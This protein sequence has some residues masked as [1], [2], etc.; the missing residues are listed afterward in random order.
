MNSTNWL[1]SYPTWI[2]SY[3]M[4][5]L[6]WQ[7]AVFGNWFDLWTKTTPT[8]MNGMGQTLTMQEKFV[9][10]LLEIEENSVRQSLDMQKM[11]W[12]NYFQMAGLQ[13]DQ[14]KKQPEEMKQNLEPFPTSAKVST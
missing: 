8:A 5:W 12:E 10:N 7:R 13:K 2:Y 14:M 1:T 4:L 9:K 6:Q 3:P 11:F